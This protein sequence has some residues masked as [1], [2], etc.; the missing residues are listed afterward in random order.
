MGGAF[1]F[2]KHERLIY[3][4]P[5]S[6]SAFLK[7]YSPKNA[8]KPFQSDDSS[9]FLYHSGFGAGHD[10]VTRTGG[11][12]MH[13]VSRSDLFPSLQQALID[14]ASKQLRANGATITIQGLDPDRHYCFLYKL[15]K[16]IGS[17]KIFPVTAAPGTVQRVT[18]LKSGLLDARAQIEQKELWFPQPHSFDPITLLASNSN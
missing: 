16:S 4:T 12:D 18:P 8:I 2:W 3:P 1:T 11:F 17:I 10:Y 9:F 14:D 5:E 15:G 13:F 6:E 7:N